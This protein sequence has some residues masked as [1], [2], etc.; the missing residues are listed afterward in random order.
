[1]GW[2]APG[3]RL[4][5]RPRRAGPALCPVGAASLERHVEG[6]DRAVAV[7]L[8]EAEARHAAAHAA[9]EG[10]VVGAVDAHRRHLARAAHDEVHREAAE[11]GVAA[12]LGAHARGQR[13]DA[14]PHD[15]VDL[16]L[17]ELVVAA[18]LAEVAEVDRAVE[19]VAVTTAA[20]P[21]AALAA[22]GARRGLHGGL[23]LD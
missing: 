19:A 2:Y 6:R 1:M 3:V 13:A 8:G 17:R 11:A 16:L 15:G 21:A 7:E 18:A 23:D 5:K 4:V 20:A 14:A 22:L 10:G 9:G 12:A